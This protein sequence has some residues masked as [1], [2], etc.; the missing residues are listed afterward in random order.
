MRKL[1]KVQAKVLR[2]LAVGEVIES[3]RYRTSGWMHMPFLY[4][5]AS[6]MRSLTK[7]GLIQCEYEESLSDRTWV[8]TEKGKYILEEHDA[9]IS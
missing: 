7:G 2:R 8:I 1:T 9:K 4:V 6:T 3:R 5:R